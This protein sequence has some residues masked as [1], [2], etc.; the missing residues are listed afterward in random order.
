MNGMKNDEHPDNS[1]SVFLGFFID[2]LIRIPGNAKALTFGALSVI[3]GSD[4]LM[5]FEPGMP[6][7]DDAERAISSK[8]PAL[9]L[10]VCIFVL[11]S[12]FVHAAFIF[13]VSD[14]KLGLIRL[15]RQALRRYFT[16]AALEGWFLSVTVILAIALFLP[17][18]VA[19]TAGQLSKALFAVG[20]V[21]FFI[22]VTILYITR[23]FAIF[24]AI[25]S[26]S[27]I[28]DALDLGYA[29]LR[30]NFSA[31]AMFTMLSILVGVLFS[32]VL[33]LVAV[34]YVA[35]SA[36][37]SVRFGIPAILFFITTIHAIVQKSSWISFF[38]LIG[39]TPPD[40]ATAECP[41]QNPEKVIQREIPGT[42]QA[43]R[44]T[45]SDNGFTE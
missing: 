29:L 14:P 39:R 3:F 34:P 26:T 6:L 11:V 28:R 41:S 45:S 10:L 5:L 20:I 24:Y 44:K 30:K 19:G 1:L 8:D 16:L 21:L 33:S 25:L 12:V 22:L 37:L 32:L 2:G 42:G 7:R 23:Q 27:S 40:D 9:L 18:S 15:C 13:S 43:C 4:M 36:N 31:V 17:T 38:R 35:D